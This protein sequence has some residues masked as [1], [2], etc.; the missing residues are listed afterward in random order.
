[1]TVAGRD[2]ALAL[3]S[4]LAAD[5]LI[6]DPASSWHP[7]ALGGRVLASAYEPWRRRRPLGQLAGGTLALAAVAG[8][9]GVAA[10]LLERSLRRFPVGGLALGLAL[11]PAFAVRELLAAGGSVADALEAGDL[12]TARAR[13]GMLVSRPTERL[14]PEEVAAAAIESLAEN[15]GD[16]VVGPL[17]AFAVAGLPGAVVYRVVNTADS[18]YGYH[19]EREWLGKSAAR[20]DDLLN[21]VPSRVSMLALAAAALV[22]G[23]ADAAAAV[24]TARRDHGLLASPNAGWPIAAM[25]GALDRRLEK[26]GHYAVGA[27]RPAPGPED[28]RRASALV[29]T[30][31]ALLTVV[32]VGAAAC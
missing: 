29:V 31:A 9:A 11:K 28:V 3:C 8:A 6:G 26:P 15:L 19:D 22:A 23:R 2:R 32:L 27:A 14:R 7:T 20:V 1:V 17:L 16:S 4:A 30:A 12:D 5:A 24:A 13:V 25:A 18:M 10:A 21:L